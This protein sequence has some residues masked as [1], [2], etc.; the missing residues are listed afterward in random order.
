MQG[1]RVAM[2]RL[3]A[4]VTLSLGLFGAII[5]LCA[6][7]MASAPSIGD[8]AGKFQVLAEEVPVFAAPEPHAPR[9][10][11][12]QRGAITWIYLRRS[13]A[14]CA[15]TWVLVGPAAWACDS[16][17]QF[18]A[19]EPGQQTQPASSEVIE[20]ARIASQGALGYKTVEHAEEQLPDAELQPG[21][22]VGIVAEQAIQGEVYGRTTHGIWI[23]RRD[24]V[25]VAPSNFEGTEIEPA[26]IESVI[27]HVADA[28]L[29][30]SAGA[31]AP[32]L[33][34][35]V[36]AQ[37][38]LPFG[39]I[40]VDKAVPRRSI[41]GAPL[42]RT[43]FSRLTRLPVLEHQ[44]R[45]D[46][47]EWFRIAEG[48]LSDQQIRVPSVVAP[49]DGVL[50][51][52]RWLDVDRQTQTLVA[53]IGRVPIF[54]TMVSTG[55]GPFHGPLATPAGTHRIW[56]KLAFSD[57]DNLDEQAQSEQLSPVAPYAVEAVPWVMFFLRGYG[58][59]ATYWHSAFGT[60]KSHGCINLSLRD[61]ARLFEFSSPRLAPGWQ[62][63][64]P[65]AYDPG[66]LVR[67]R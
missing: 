3:S 37:S 60:P 15:G 6:G 10:G 16:P 54:A 63:A 53:Y 61:A 43:A 33:R 64:H 27:H 66:T 11:T 59:H 30:T 58:L 14:G 21:F 20:Y 13:L 18:A 5:A 19:L 45:T 8:T 52:E 34:R 56:V 47:S 46:H 4:K 12:L 31:T 50:P 36:A 1:R 9:R 40:Y 42:P 32:P 38:A 55:Q 51:N 29:A 17:G 67:V 49:P 41:H 28:T 57:M 62:A 39:W 23:L 26:N 25:A 24:L 48:W 2:M 44:V 22:F 7:A 35:S 65:Y